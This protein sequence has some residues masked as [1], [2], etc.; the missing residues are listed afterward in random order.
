[1]WKKACEKFGLSTSYKYGLDL[2]DGDEAQNYLSKHGTW[3]LDQ[4]LSKAHIKKA[5]NDS[6]TPFDF[7]RRYLEEDDEKYLKLFREC[8]ECFK[9]KRNCN[10]HKV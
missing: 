8:A 3:G 7:L 6:M 2:Q 10:G 1:M 5:K 9:G 4:E